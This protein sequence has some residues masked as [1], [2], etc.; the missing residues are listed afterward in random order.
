METPPSSSY[1]LHWHCTCIDPWREIET[2]SVKLSSPSSPGTGNSVILYRFC[3]R[4]LYNGCRLHGWLY[5]LPRVIADRADHL[6]SLIDNLGTSFLLVFPRSIDRRFHPKSINR[7]IY[8]SKCLRYN[9]VCRSFYSF[10]RSEYTKYANRNRNRKMFL[11]GKFLSKKVFPKPGKR[12]RER[13]GTR[14]RPL[15]LPALHKW[16]RYPMT[17]FLQFLLDNSVIQ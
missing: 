12:K 6:H 7:R 11:D 9:F 14:T 3:A 8:A 10:S 4:V 17:W 15:T 1:K 5:H 13:A 16:P 2:L